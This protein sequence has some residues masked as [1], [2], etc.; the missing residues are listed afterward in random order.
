MLVI[1]LLWFVAA[2]SEVDFNLVPYGWILAFSA[3]V[4]F[5]TAAV[6]I[7][8]FWTDD[9]RGLR[10]ARPDAGTELADIV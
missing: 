2:S 3:G 4:L 9:G 5:T 1:A 6:A 10:R 7:F 8:K